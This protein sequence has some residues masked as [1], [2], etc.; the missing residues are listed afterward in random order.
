LDGGPLPCV[1]A[2]KPLG[3]IAIAKADANAYID[4]AINQAYRQV[5]D[6]K[7]SAV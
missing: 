7:V 3:R 6:L 4:C 5:D 2:R 1:E